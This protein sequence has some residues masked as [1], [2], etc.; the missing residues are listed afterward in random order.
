[1]IQIGLDADQ[2][3]G[4]QPVQLIPGLGHRRCD[5][6]AQ[7]FDDGLEQVF[8]HDSVLIDG[9]AERGVLVGDPRDEDARPVGVGVELQRCECRDRA[10][11]RLLLLAL[12]LV[13]PVEQVAFEL[14]MGREHVAVEQHGD[15]AD[16]GANCRQCGSKSI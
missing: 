3:V 5:R 15:V 2:G 13:T 14:R 11:Q 1:M 9:D 10:G 7:D 16:G 12:P 4:H 8:V 6:G